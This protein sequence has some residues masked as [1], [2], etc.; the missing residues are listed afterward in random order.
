MSFFNK[1]SSNNMIPNDYKRYDKVLNDDEILE[2]AL[3]IDKYKKG[4]IDFNELLK[5]AK[6]I[7][8]AIKPIPIDFSTKKMTIEQGKIIKERLE[9]KDYIYEDIRGFLLDIDDKKAVFYMDYKAIE[10]LAKAG[11]PEYISSLISILDW[12]IKNSPK[13]EI[14]DML[15]AKRLA[16]LSKLNKYTNSTEIEESKKER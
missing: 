1:K 10:I 8:I 14:K 7:D 9:N 15:K 11:L 5:E 13:N 12:E 4:T 6:S 2:C 3:L 16:Y